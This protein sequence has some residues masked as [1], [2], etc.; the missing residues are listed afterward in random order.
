MK[1]I[2]VSFHGSKTKTDFD[3]S[4]SSSEFSLKVVGIENAREIVLAGGNIHCIT[5]QQPAEP[6]SVAEN[7]H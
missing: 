4:S 6:T 7:G 3:F 2:S 1:T 5:Q